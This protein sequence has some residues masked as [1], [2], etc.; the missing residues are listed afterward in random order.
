VF[1]HKGSG[2]LVDD[3]ERHSCHNIFWCYP[4]EREI[5]R[6]VNISSNQKTNEVTYTSYYARQIFTKIHKAMQLDNDGVFLGGRTLKEVHKYLQLPTD[7]HRVMD[8][9]LTICEQWHE[10]CV[11]V[12]PSQKIVQVVSKLV[13]WLPTCSCKQVLLHKGI[14]V[15]RKIGIKATISKDIISYLKCFWSKLGS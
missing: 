8:R 5:S 15:G 6:I 4:F 11:V 2:K 10:E 7:V 3:V 1:G 12:V 14:I 13:Q 9:N